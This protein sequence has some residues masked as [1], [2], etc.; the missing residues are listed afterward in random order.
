MLNLNHY[1]LVKK[2]KYLILDL[3]RVKDLYLFQHNM[4]YLIIMNLYNLVMV[5]YLN[6]RN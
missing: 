2:Y 4:I 6:M 1:I 3:N 5:I